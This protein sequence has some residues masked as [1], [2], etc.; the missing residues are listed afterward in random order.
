MPSL[1]AAQRGVLRVV[2]LEDAK[3]EP[4]DL[5]GAPAA[6]ARTQQ[7]QVAAGFTKADALLDQGADSTTVEIRD[8]VKVD[9]D[10]EP[11]LANE[12]VDLRAQRV[13]AFLEDEA[14]G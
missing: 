9:D 2:D 14:A 3:Q 11:A 12:A 1:E 7:H 10:V 6:L 13:L 5:Q 8:V 4:R